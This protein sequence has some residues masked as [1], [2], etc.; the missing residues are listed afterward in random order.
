LDLPG[1]ILKVRTAPLTEDT[2]VAMVDFR[3]TNTSDYSAKVRTVRVF[4][5]DKSGNRA[6]GRIVPDPDAKRV[7][8][9]IPILGQKYNPS[10][11]L[12]DQIPARTTWDRMV[13]ASFQ[14]PDAQLQERKQL[15]VSIEEIDGKIFEMKER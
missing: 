3:V 2:S 1:Q 7:F 4:A 14:F 15:I 10:L 12:W 5:E 6:E 13:G 8:D 11:I 9:A